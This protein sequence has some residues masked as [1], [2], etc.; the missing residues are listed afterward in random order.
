[1]CCDPCWLTDE[2][3]WSREHLGLAGTASRYR[4]PSRR[5]WLSPP[6][7]KG[8]GL[9]IPSATGAHLCAAPS[10]AYGAIVRQRYLRTSPTIDPSVRCLERTPPRQRI[11]AQ[12]FLRC[13]RSGSSFK[14]NRQVTVGRWIRRHRPTQIG[15]LVW[16]NVA[17]LSRSSFGASGGKD[18]FWNRFAAATGR[19][20]PMRGWPACA[21]AG[22]A[23]AAAITRATALTAE[24]HSSRC[25]CWRA[26]R[27]PV[28]SPL[29]HELSSIQR[30]GPGRQ[31]W[32]VGPLS[33]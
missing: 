4:G 10:G 24:E 17:R 18:R 25:H 22:A 5:L 32:G 27:P 11:G 33:T 12:C 1:M 3:R 14:L 9:A 20:P 26:A 13:A 19:N 6:D 16:K 30:C 28:A 29:A 15:R 23:S 8:G 2:S 7:E 21:A 31:R